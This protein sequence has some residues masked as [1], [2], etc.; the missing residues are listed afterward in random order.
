MNSPQTSVRDEQTSRFHRHPAVAALVILLLSAVVRVGFAARMDPS[1]LVRA[2]QDASTYIVPATNLL[3]NGT[4]TN[5]YGLPEVSRTPG[6]PA[7]LAALF[8]ATGKDL[9]MAL[10]VQAAFLSFGVLFLYL[11]A[12]KILSPPAAFI[13][14]LIAAL[15]PWGAVLAGIPMTDGLYLFM[16]AISFYLLK[17]LE[18]SQRRTQMVLRAILLG[19][20]IGCTVLVKPVW[21]LVPLFGGALLFCKALRGK[22]LLAMT[23]TLALAVVP[24]SLWIHRNSREIGYAGL[25]TISG[26]TAWFYLAQRVRAYTEGGDRSAYHAAARKQ[27]INAKLYPT[28]YDAE[29]WNR[30]LEVFRNHPFITAYC[31]FLSAAEHTLHPGDRRI[32]QGARLDFT[33]SFGVLV[34]LWGALLMLVLIGGWFAATTKVYKDSMDATW[35]IILFSI[36]TFLTLLSGISYGAGSRLRAPMELIVPVLASIG[37]LQGGKLLLR[38]ITHKRN[39]VIATDGSV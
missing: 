38:H 12:R 14:G 21:P 22:R 8:F 4:F 11:L 32:L 28:K 34:S 25:S 5:R 33:G 37:L 16:L 18:E 19:L 13:A 10:I 27:S 23:I 30:A 39:V 2:Y 1:D 36:C 3:E 26:A 15:S 17:L 29:N 31:L 35:L 7:L 24:V 20:V 6:Y 9:R